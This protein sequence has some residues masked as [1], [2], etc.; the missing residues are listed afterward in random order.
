MM[1]VCVNG[2]KREVPKGATLETLIESF[3]L[4]NKSIVLELNHKVVD[5][6][7]FS[8]TRLTENDAVEI[9]HFVGG[10]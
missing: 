7:I 6:S 3:R 5:R 1:T 8:T 4:K 10:G 9:V 2:L